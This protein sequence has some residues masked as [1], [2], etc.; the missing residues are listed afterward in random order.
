MKLISVSLLLLISTVIIRAQVDT[1]SEK[2][3][4]NSKPTNVYSQ[5]DNFLEYKKAPDYY[6]LG[7]NPRIS[8][9]PN[10][11]NLLLMEVPFRYIS[12]SGVFGLADTRLRYFYIP[13][14]D[15]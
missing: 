9:A 10:E 4:D 1:Q 7:Y 2:Q 3:K 6:T 5:V 11:D 12:Y 15:Y 14:R 8:Y 13:Y